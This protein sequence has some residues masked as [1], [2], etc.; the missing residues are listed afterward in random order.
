MNT[1]K[2]EVINLLDKLPDSCTIEEIQYH[3]YVINKVK[4]GIDRADKEGEISEKEAKQR[5]NRWISD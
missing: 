5:L 2:K 3:L 4:T 1:V